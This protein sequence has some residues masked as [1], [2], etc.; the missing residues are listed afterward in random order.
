MDTFS[1]FFLVYKVL[2][3]KHYHTIWQRTTFAHQVVALFNHDQWTIGTNHGWDYLLLY[4]EIGQ[5]KWNEGHGLGLARSGKTKGRSVCFMVNNQW[6]SGREFG[7]S[8]S[9]VYS[10]TRQTNLDE[11][12]GVIDRPCWPHGRR[13]LL[14]WPEI[15]ITPTWGKFSQGTTNTS[16]VLCMEVTHL[17]LSSA[18]AFP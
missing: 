14:L 12:Y 15:L 7:C 4:L 11:L 18:S 13:L 10:T 16:A 3:T 8:H 5:D 2:L 9:G 6:C 1:F 17:F